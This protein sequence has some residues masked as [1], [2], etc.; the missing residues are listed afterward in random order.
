MRVCMPLVFLHCLTSL[1]V[2]KTLYC[3]AYVLTLAAAA[4]GLSVLPRCTTSCRSWCCATTATTA[5]SATSTLLATSVG[6]VAATTRAAWGLWGQT[7]PHLRQQ[8]DSEGEGAA[9]VCAATGEGLVAGCAGFGGCGGC[10]WAWALKARGFHAVE[11]AVFSPLLASPSV[12]PCMY[13]IACRM[14]V[15]THLCMWLSEPC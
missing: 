13:T 5:Q 1:A 3:I 15:V 2:W 4:A 10:G 12:W 7:S 9:S 14:F 6:S 11:P 8:Q